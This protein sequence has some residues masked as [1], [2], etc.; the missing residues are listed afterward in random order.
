[1]CFALFNLHRENENEK[2]I[3]STGFS[4][5]EFKRRE[6]ICVI[7]TAP[8]AALQFPNEQFST[9]EESDGDVDDGWSTIYYYLTAL[10]QQ[11]GGLFPPLIDDNLL[12]F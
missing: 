8:G 7:S 1:M 3:R 5:E 4:G 10:L 2:E 11:Q 12:L 6:R 9:T